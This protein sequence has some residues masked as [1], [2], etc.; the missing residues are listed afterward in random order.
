LR[1]RATKNVVVKD[2]FLKT[3]CVR[4]EFCKKVL[5]GAQVFAKIQNV[6]EK[7]QISEKVENVAVSSPR[8]VLNK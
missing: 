5:K 4:A 8:R 3:S 1:T 2:T 7:M 6:G